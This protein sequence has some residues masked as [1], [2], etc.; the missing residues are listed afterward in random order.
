MDGYLK[1]ATPNP[2]LLIFVLTLF[3]PV[4]NRAHPAQK[5]QLTTFGLVLILSL[6]SPM[7]IEM[8]TLRALGHQNGDFSVATS[9]N[10]AVIT[11]NSLQPQLAT[12]MP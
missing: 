7:G 6:I 3:P 12:S 9:L 1:H 11:L 5:V 2:E 4:K 10:A 8:L